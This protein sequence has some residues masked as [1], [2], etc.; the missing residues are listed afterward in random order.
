MTANERELILKGVV[1]IKAIKQLTSI[2]EAQLLNYLK[3]TGKP[4]GVLFN[5]GT[6]KLEW[7]RMVLTRPAIRV[8]WRPFADAEKGTAN[9]RE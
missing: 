7:K 3:A 2:E 5:F 1:E 8:H 6:P 4:V 9:E